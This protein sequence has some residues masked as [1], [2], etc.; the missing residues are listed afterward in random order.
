VHYARV[1]Q[2]K[3]DAPQMAS[4]DRA[5]APTP[6]SSKKRTSRR[7]TA[8]KKRPADE[9]AVDPK[10]AKLGRQIGVTT[11]RMMQTLYTCR[12]TEDL[13]EV[14][15]TLRVLTRALAYELLLV[16][17]SKR[18]PSE[19]VAFARTFVRAWQT[20]GN[21]RPWHRVLQKVFMVHA[22][23]PR[24]GAAGVAFILGQLRMQVLVV[25]PE[26]LP[27]PLRKP[28]PE[29]V[30]SAADALPGIL[31]RIT[32]RKPG[33]LRRRLSPWGAAAEFASHFGDDLMP[34]TESQALRTRRTPV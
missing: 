22:W 15:D 27:V 23:I 6:K 5:M 25:E 17:V 34:P 21:A 31:A 29:A 18:V 16:G 1:A 20:R 24:D 3:L 14:D 32:H 33:G 10:F 7:P 19:Q 26:D 2:L 8:A 9:T 12:A 28:Q 11:A 30:A 4:R 13:V